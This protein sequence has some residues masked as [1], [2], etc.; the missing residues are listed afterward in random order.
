[1][2]ADDPNQRCADKVNDRSK[3]DVECTCMADKMSTFELDEDW[4]GEVFMYYY[5]TNF[6]QNH[7]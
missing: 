6:Y 5:L 3:T 1:M 4:E 2:N 7:R